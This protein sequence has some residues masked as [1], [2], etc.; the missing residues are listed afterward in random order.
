MADTWDDKVRDLF[1]QIGVSYDKK[2]NQTAFLALTEDLEYPAIQQDPG[3]FQL[4]LHEYIQKVRTAGAEIDQS[5]CP[6]G[7]FELASDAPCIISIR[8]SPNLSLLRRIGTEFHIDPDILLGHLPFSWAFRVLS[9]PSQPRASISIRLISLGSYRSYPR[10]PATLENQREKNA[11][12]ERYNQR[13][14]DRNTPNA[15]QYRRVNLHGDSFLSVEQQ[16]TFVPVRRGASWSAVLFNDCGPKN[17][18][19]QYYH[20]RLPVQFFNLIDS[21]LLSL[22]I[23]DPASL[24]SKLCR[25][26]DPC[27]SRVQ[28]DSIISNNL[29][30]A[31]LADPMIIVGDLLRTSAQ[32][33]AIFFTFL[34]Y[35]H[36]MFGPTYDAEARVTTLRMDKAVTD[37]AE[38]Y[39]RDILKFIKERRSPA[40]PECPSEPE[41]IASARFL[42]VL[43]EDFKR[44]QEEAAAISTACRDAIDIEMNVISVRLSEAGLAQAKTVHSLTFLAYFFI[45]SAFI[46]S[47]FGM[48]VAPFA[49]NPPLWQ[50][51]ATVVPF[52]SFFLLIAARGPVTRGLRVVARELQILWSG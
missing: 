15:D 33:W 50:F 30:N 37:R 34:R 27:Q 35:S 18:N 51:F 8:G 20:K 16:V 32:S 47:V 2:H 5:H 52:T 42:Q 25:H 17:V 36:L 46:A 40:W 44:L 43:R 4:P 29:Y 7:N 45:P 23:E 3:A 11:E 19:G 1:L 14:F 12:I 10:S 31:S 49:K 26:S 9:L 21:G 28:S 41:R 39:F 13:H 22:A 24:P 48:N 38:V 6:R